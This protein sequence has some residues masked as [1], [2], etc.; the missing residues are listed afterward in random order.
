MNGEIYP[1]NSAFRALSDVYP[2]M[3]KIGTMW[4]YWV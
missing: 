2:A 4:F 1:R 3:F